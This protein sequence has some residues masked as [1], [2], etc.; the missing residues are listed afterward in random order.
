MFSL[1][2]CF[3]ISHHTEALWKCRWAGDGE[4]LGITAHPCPGP[5]G[6]SATQKAQ[7][8]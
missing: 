7:R 2:A 1:I 6:H 5:A 4:L 8:V 3:V